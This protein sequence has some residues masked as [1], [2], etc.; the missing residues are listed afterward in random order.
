MYYVISAANPNSEDAKGLVQQI[1]NQVPLFSESR[2][3]KGEIFELQI[4]KAQFKIGSLDQLMILN[5]TA[6]K[7]DA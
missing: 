4:D 7:L 3:D 2:Q 1:G 6:Q 5:E